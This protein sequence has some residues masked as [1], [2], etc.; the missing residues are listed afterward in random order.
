MSAGSRSEQK[1]DTDTYAIDG[2]IALC[3]TVVVVEVGGAR[4]EG[5]G[6]AELTDEGF[7][8]FC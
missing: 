8:D 1:I 3:V 5:V 6:T 7:G 4:L 2:L